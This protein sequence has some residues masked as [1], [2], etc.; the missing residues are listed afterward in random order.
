MRQAKEQSIAISHKK[1]RNDKLIR[2]RAVNIAISPKK[3]RNDQLIIIHIDQK[4]AV[5]VAIFPKKGRDY[6]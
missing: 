6:L 3:G 1:G 2:K 5:D 4:K